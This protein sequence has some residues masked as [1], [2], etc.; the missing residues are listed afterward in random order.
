M[1]RLKLHTSLIVA[2]IILILILSLSTIFIYKIN[3]EKMDKQLI[4]YNKA[5][6]NH[7]ASSITESI[8]EIYG[9]F[10]IV[11]NL[12]YE[13]VDKNTGEIN[14][15]S[16][17]Q[18][19]E[20]TSYIKESSKII[21]DII[22]YPN[23]I[24]AFTTNG[25]YSF[26]NVFEDIYSNSK[27]PAS[28]WHNYNS[29]NNYVKIL[30]SSI[31]INKTISG[32]NT[33][34]NLIGAVSGRSDLNKDYN[35]VIFIDADKMF[36][37]SEQKIYL[38]NSGYCV[39][40][41]DRN[42]ILQ[43]NLEQ[44]DL[45]IL[46]KSI[47]FN[48]TDKMLNINGSNY[49]MVQ[50]DLH[51]YT[52]VNKI[53]DDSVLSR[54]K[55]I[56]ILIIIISILTCFVISFL[57]ISFIYKPVKRILLLIG[58]DNHSHEN[59]FK[60]ID[61]EIKNLISQNVNLSQTV[62]TLNDINIRNTFQK[63]INGKGIKEDDLIKMCSA[64]AENNSNINFFVV[65]TAEI[66]T[67][68]NEETGSNISNLSNQPWDDFEILWKQKLPYSIIYEFET[69]KFTSLVLLG[70]NTTKKTLDT[71]LNNLIREFESRYKNMK[72]NLSISDIHSNI[73]DIKKAYIESTKCLW[74]KPIISQNPVTY[75][76]K[77][78]Q[79]HVCFFPFE[80]I[81]QLKSKL[82]VG[83][84][85]ECQD[86]ICKIITKNVF[87]NLDMF[88]FKNLSFQLL[89]IIYHAVP[90]QIS[91]EFNQ[92][93]NFLDLSIE[94]YALNTIEDFIAFF[95]NLIISVTKIIQKELK[96]DSLTSQEKISFIKEYIRLHYNEDIYLE[97][98]S[99]MVDLS[100]KYFSR[101]F[102][103]ATGTNLIEY[104]NAF[105][106]LKA[107]ELLKN[108]E[109]TLNEIATMVG[110]KSNSALTINFNKYI[111]IPPVKYRIMNYSE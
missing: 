18:L 27:Y 81:E 91:E 50:T 38:K 67:N 44:A 94:L 109:L 32:Y 10:Q 65:I 78:F 87:L 110:Y 97:N 107:K 55:L 76:N 85:K 79:P 111:G 71:D 92:N 89:R 28:F 103:K 106:V 6:V 62:D 57:F 29:N 14:Y 2:F 23:A 21:H 95:K 60:V 82:M 100:P 24:N 101:S 69:F 4:E 90:I 8:N 53:I 20:K 35:I 52:I 48:Y 56:N 40:D 42:I 17:M 7:F 104:L 102:K 108:Q 61:K 99:A 80:L 15:Y 5:I 36:R 46:K 39:F 70:K 88:T 58:H 51:K 25:S 12:N 73:M 68:H 49:Y 72:I 84:A 33:R 105:R 11:N 37:I 86:V 30:P 74:I 54:T 31:Y 63:V 1:F 13:L 34:N 66:I 77:N 93:N 96:N 47:G 75:Y 98:L 16:A 45:N 59:E 9:T 19:I 22:I 41:K 64:I 26:I 3:I 43:E 83:D